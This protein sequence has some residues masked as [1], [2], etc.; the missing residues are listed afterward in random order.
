M[1]PIIEVCVWDSH[2]PAVDYIGAEFSYWRS[3][4]H[5]K[6]GPSAYYTVVRSMEMINFTN[7]TINNV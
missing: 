7:L 6:C 2:C 3:D 4:F 5:S 1:I